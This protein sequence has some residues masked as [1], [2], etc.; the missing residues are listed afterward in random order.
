MVSV[1]AFL[2]RIA[3]TLSSALLFSYAAAPYLWSG[4]VALQRP[5]TIPFVALVNMLR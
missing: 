4:E 5:L 2:S 3:H 1:D